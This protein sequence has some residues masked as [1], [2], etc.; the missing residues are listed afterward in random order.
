M[1]RL[2]VFL[3]NWI[4][5]VVMATPAI[6]ALR[7]HFA[8][9]ELVAVCKPYVSGMVDGSPWFDAI[10]PFDHRG[11]SEARFVGALRALRR[12]RPEAA[13]L[14][15][16]T[17]RAALLARIAGCRTAVGF[18]RHGRDLLLTKRLYAE[19]DSKGGF[20]PSPVMDD[21]NRIARTLGTPEPG[22]R[23]ELFATPNGE[24][25]AEHFW[26]AAGLH[27]FAN[28]IG[29]NPG[30]AFGTS[31]HWPTAHFVEVAR[32]FAGRGHGVLVL[33]GPAER[34]VSREIAATANRS[35]VATLADGPLSLDLTKSIVRRLRLLVTTDSGPRHIALAFGV[36]AVSLYGPTHRGWTITHSPIDIAVQKTVPCGPCQLKVC[37]LDHRCMTELTPQ[38]AIRAAEQ[39]L[40]AAAPRGEPVTEWRH[41][42]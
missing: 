8:G 5:D 36:P 42:G 26:K 38:D 37:P 32:H 21:Y 6:R 41:A 18:A 40:A 12:F 27:R 14:F 20:R 2:A 13:A 3:P 28:I 22:H 29:L 15:P 34:D 4:G 7:S 9:F 24:A 23:M 17:F 1:K 16:N 25:A 33:C 39:L 19:R 11:T 35:G 10:V 30:G 31:K